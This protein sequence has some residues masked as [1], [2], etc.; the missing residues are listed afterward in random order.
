MVGRIGIGV[1]AIFTCLFLVILSPMRVSAQQ[2]KSAASV[3]ALVKSIGLAKPA[4]TRAPDFNLRDTN[5]NLANLSGYRGRMVLLNFW[6]TWCGPCRD[7]MPSMENL[8]RSFGSHELAVVAVNKRENAAVVTTFMRTRGF[9]FTAPLDT[10]GRVADSYRVYGIPVTYLI[11][12][13]GEAIGMKSGLKDWAS[14]EVVAAFRK[15]IA[16]DGS[17]GAMAGSIRIEPPAPLPTALRAKAGMLVRGQQDAQSEA[18]AKLERGDEIVP[19]GK[20]SGGG[21]YWFL[22]KTKRGVIGWVRGEEVEEA[23]K[24]M[25]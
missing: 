13:N 21:D 20:V 6:A 23:S 18:I 17:G 5:G 14:P 22:V 12:G 16:K 24:K 15:L 8:S 4:M 2:D 3:D 10:D 7:E 19:L 25:K 1:A 9:N 11:A